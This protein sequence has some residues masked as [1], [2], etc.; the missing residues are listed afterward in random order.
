MFEKL[1]CAELENLEF[2]SFSIS[3][4]SAAVIRELIGTPT[5]IDLKA[6]ARFAYLRLEAAKY[7]MSDN[8]AR[9]ERAGR[10]H[11][12]WVD[13]QLESLRQKDRKH[14]KAF[15][16]LALVRDEGFFNGR[17]TWPQIKQNP[18][19]GVPSDEDVV[20]AIPYLPST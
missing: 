1:K 15:D 14:R 2:E 3:S 7:H 5:S 8:T 11:W 13:D 12:D 10:S 19:F 9:R 16:V 17:N 6:K 18:N 20:A 4:L